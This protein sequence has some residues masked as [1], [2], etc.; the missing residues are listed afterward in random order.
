MKQDLNGN[1]IK[2]GGRNEKSLGTERTALPLVSKT[3]CVANGPRESRKRL[4][5]ETNRASP[6]RFLRVWDLFQ[7]QSE[8]HDGF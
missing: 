6:V 8:T 7:E 2:R 1:F 4:S 3:V 5:E